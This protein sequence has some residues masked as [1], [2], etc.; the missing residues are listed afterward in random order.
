MDFVIGLLFFILGSA[1]VFGLVT[2]LPPSGM[3]GEHPPAESHG[4]PAA[5][6]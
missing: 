4:A 5:H 2:L 1:A 6:H 3:T